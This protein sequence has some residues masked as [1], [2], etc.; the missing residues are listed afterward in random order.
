MPYH[1]F[2]DDELIEETQKIPKGK[3]NENEALEE[4]RFI[5]TC[6]KIGLKIE[7]LKHL[8]YKDVAKIMLCFIDATNLDNTNRTRKAT[9]SDW[10]ALAG[11]R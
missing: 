8:E 3:E 2:V 11:G 6:L 7:D 5:A 4:H 10:D 1:H 9:Q